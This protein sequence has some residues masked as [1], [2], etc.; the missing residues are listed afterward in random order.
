MA[1]NYTVDEL[2][3]RVK[4][5]CQLRASNQ[6]LTTAEIVQVCDEEIQQN[7]FPSLMKVREDYQMTTTT[8]VL[9]SGIQT[10]RLPFSSASS[11]IDHIE[12]VQL[13][14]TTALGAGILPRVETPQSAVMTGINQ[15]STTS[16]WTGCY[17]LLGDTIQVFP[18]PTAWTAQN[19]VLRIT[20]EW[21]PARLALLETASQ[22][23]SYSANGSDDINVILSAP[24]ASTMA[25]NDRIDFVPSQ[26]PLMALILDALIVDTGGDP[27]IVVNP[28]YSMLQ[29]QALSVLRSSPGPYMT[30]RGYTPVFPL[31]DAWWNAAILACSASVCRI[32][33]DSDGYAQNQDA[34]LQAIER[35]IELQSN[36][37]RK[38]PHI[39]FDRTSPLRRSTGKG[40]WGW[41][42]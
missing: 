6:K 7:L 17:L 23:V 36:R 25:T 28:G 30:P 18:A 40:W 22:C 41:Q 11:T 19:I 14:G 12:W 2:V 13:S 31:P 42:R 10:Y 3:A 29:A 32:L 39:P 26:P 37:V 21:R 27:T 38:Q 33:G 20:H 35:L 8:L 9:E 5:T 24:I 15:T 1:L 34:S 16:G 4:R